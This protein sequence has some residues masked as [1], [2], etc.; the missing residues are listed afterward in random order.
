MVIG[1]AIGS[2]S[3]WLEQIRPHSSRTPTLIQMENTECGAAALGII[4]GYYRR[5]VP[6]PELRRECG[7]S[8]D[9]SKA[10]NVL[11]A[12]RYYG[13][14]AKGFKMPTIEDV[15]S[16]RL[17]CIVF[18]N[19]NHF[20]VVERFLKDS[21]DLNDPASGRRRV[22]AE[23]F[24]KSYTGVVLVM[25]PGS[26]FQPGGKKPGILPGLIGR[27]NYSRR[28]IAFCLIAGLLLT[29]PRLAVPAFSQVFVDEIL[30]KNRQ[31]WL[32]PLVLGMLMT[33]LL[34]GLLA[35][36]R[37]TYLRRLLIK[38]SVIMSGQFLWHTLRLPAEFYAQRY[39]GEISSRAEL[40]DKVAGIVTGPLA[41]TVIDAIMI[42]FYA[43][44]MFVYDWVLTV[45]TILFAVLN[46]LVLRFLSA[47]RKDINSKLAQENGKTVG[48]AIGGLYAIES[49]KASGLESD[50][51]SKFAGYYSKMVNAQRE[52]VLP[53]QML[54]AIPTLLTAIAGTVILIIGGFRVMDGTLSIGML[55][56]YQGL[57]Q[58]FLS[59]VNSLLNFGGLLQTLETD[60]NRLDD[61]LQNPL[62][63]ETERPTE[64]DP[65][66][67]ITAQSF[68]LQGY[69]ELRNLSFGYSRLAA[70]LFENLSLTVQPGQRIALIGSSGSG[71]S[72]VAKLVT[73]LYKPWEGEIWFDGKSRT[74]IPRSILSHSLAMVEQEIF[75]FAGTVRDNLTLWD[76]T[77]P[78]EDLVQACKDAV[79]HDLILSLPGGYDAELNEG[80]TNLSG[81]QR[82]RLE[83]ARS[84]VRNPSILVLD[85]ATS[86]LDAETE[87][88]I[89]R[90]LR[91][92]GCSCIVVA[93]RLSTIRDCDEIIVLDR[94]KVAQRGTHEELRQQAGLY[95]QLASMTADLEESSLV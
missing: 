70:P 95:Q 27:L 89:D 72:T 39:A 22:S 57:T 32:R 79:I 83:I 68:R 1:M 20:L 65:A 50:V 49:V 90:N 35:R 87:L 29:L 16:A 51:F 24:E 13:L 41:T 10:S 91:R 62:D 2:I 44:I 8:R 69:V 92:R 21:V 73:G 17:P 37:L 28:A 77:I 80:G 74:E 25:E 40:N 45:I 42:V 7:V 23:E 47:S 33:A 5:I 93:H 78:L 46:I 14:D 12:A 59:P 3:T 61:V 9:G 63:P 76:S 34:Q 84:L 43:S 82:Q 58:S 64:T 26:A 52:A 15:K 85:E 81:G 88:L 36:L 75:L 30:L 6:L 4:L 53:N 18:W 31:E 19:F 56:A 11:K 55:V 66:S 38:L 71:K 86:A 67:A 54:S 48:V 94:G 60:L